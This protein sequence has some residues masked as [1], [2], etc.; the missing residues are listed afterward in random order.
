MGGKIPLNLFLESS[1][2]YILLLVIL[3]KTCINSTGR[4]VSLA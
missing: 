2:L 3:T 4:L 1:E